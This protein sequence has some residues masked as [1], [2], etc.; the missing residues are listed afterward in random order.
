MAV[1]YKP[2]KQH[3]NQWS[4]NAAK[5][6]SS[7][8]D[9]RGRIIMSVGIGQ[10]ITSFNNAEDVIEEIS[11]DIYR[12]ILQSIFVDKEKYVIQTVLGK[13]PGI[14]ITYENNLVMH[15]DYI[16]IMVKRIK[17]AI[18]K[19]DREL[20]VKAMVNYVL[21]KKG[22]EKYSDEYKTVTKQINSICHTNFPSELIMMV[23]KEELCFAERQFDEKEVQISEMSYA[24][25]LYH[26]GN[27]VCFQNYYHKDYENRIIKELMYRALK[28]DLIVI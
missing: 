28:G 3:V 12:D 20:I 24:E 27:I 1:R 17:E 10:K 8:K 25:L 26:V 4:F 13:T 18:S 5:E 19:L 14:I 22:I 15:N 6:E 23:V 7:R 16:P 2:Y 21:N 11:E 9:A